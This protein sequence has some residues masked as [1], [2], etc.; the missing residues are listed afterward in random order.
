M[1][2][3]CRRAL[4]VAVLVDVSA[5]I[6]QSDLDRVR[7]TLSV[8]SAHLSPS[9]R[10]SLVT[11]AANQKIHNRLNENASFV[12]N[13]TEVVTPGRNLGVAIRKTRIQVFNGLTVGDRAG[14]P[15]VLVIILRGRSDDP[16]SSVLEADRLRSEGIRIVVVQIGVDGGM[17]DE[18]RKLR[19]LDVEMDDESD[20]LNVARVD[21]LE[22]IHKPLISVLC[23][24][25]QFS[26]PGNAG[27][28]VTCE[29]YY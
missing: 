5:N 10:M 8:L 3:T 1:L 12:I 19:G 22:V 29:R 13:R 28:S 9:S 18:T 4:D 23:S 11:F 26:G 25:H 17:V 24:T 2:P 20:R 7:L 15:D 6:L 14:V 21:Q 16:K 27:K